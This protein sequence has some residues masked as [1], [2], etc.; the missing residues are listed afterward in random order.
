MNKESQTVRVIRE[1]KKRKVRNYEFSK[2]H[3]LS[4]TKCI[5]NIRE[6][7]FTVS[8]EKEYGSDGKYHGVNYYWIPR[9]KP[10]HKRPEQAMEYEEVKPKSNFFTSRMRSL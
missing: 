9:S 5:S 8:M 6:R 1:L 7:G 3:I 2:M 4:H 10:S